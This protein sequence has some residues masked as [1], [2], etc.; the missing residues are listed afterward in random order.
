MPKLS[1]EERILKK[2]QEELRGKH[3]VVVG[4]DIYSASTQKGA[5]T[6]LKKARKDH[7]KKT[8]LYTYIPAEE[9]LI[10]WL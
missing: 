8:P 3:V 10:L 6:M 4:E 9:L 1:K 5:E 7:P 2:H